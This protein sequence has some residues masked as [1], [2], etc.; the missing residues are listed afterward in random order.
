[1]KAEEVERFEVREPVR[2]VR[3]I[4]VVREV[5]EDLAEEERDDREV[6]ADEAPGGKADKDPEERGCNDDDRH[7]P[8]R[9]PVQPQPLRVEQR[10]GVGA[11]APEGDVAEVE[12][13]RPADDD[14]QPEREHRVDEDVEAHALV[15]LVAGGHGEEGRAADDDR[16]AGRRRKPI[17]GS[18]ECT[19]R[20]ASD[21]GPF[22]GA[23]DPFVDSDRGSLR[24]GLHYT[25]LMSALPSRPV[26][27]TRRTMIRSEKTQ[28]S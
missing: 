19:Q 14:V 4:E 17:P 5:E 24:R 20:S 3:E 8:E 13:A 10:I 9:R 6:V 15:V 21:L 1:M 23:G 7:R 25:F 11:E 26:G 18:L 27:R 16:K 2:A 28:T 12:Q 22:L